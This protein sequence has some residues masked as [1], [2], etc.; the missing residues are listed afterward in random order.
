MLER[1]DFSFVFGT[2]VLSQHTTGT[3]SFSLQ[4]PVPSFHPNYRPSFQPTNRFH[5]F[6]TS[7]QVTPLSSLFCE[8][9]R[10]QAENQ[11]LWFSRPVFPSDKVCGPP[12]LLSRRTHRLASFG[13]ASP[14][15]V[16]PFHCKV[17]SRK[18]HS[19][20]GCDRSLSQVRT[21]VDYWPFG[22]SRTS[23]LPSVPCPSHF[24]GQVFPLNSWACIHRLSL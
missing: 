20:I 24:L 10:F 15:H 1:P 21:P 9:R 18:S 12:D 11:R 6:K 4:L 19:T 23:L 8:L 16:P 14:W 3:S 5:H 7:F 13:T 22:V 17:K 2:K